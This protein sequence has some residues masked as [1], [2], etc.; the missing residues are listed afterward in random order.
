[1]IGKCARG[2]ACLLLC[3]GLAHAQSG[4]GDASLEFVVMTMA[5]VEGCIRADD[6]LRRTCTRI[7][8]LP[9]K[10]NANCALPVQPFEVRNARS[11]L[12]FKEAFRTQ[13]AENDALLADVIKRGNESF[14]REFAQLREGRI[15]MFDLEKLSRELNGR[16]ANVERRWLDPN[17]WPK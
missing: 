5:H 13:I 7:V 11:V 6:L 15:S 2:I 12:A 1:V 16:C 3:C 9:A 4:K 10:D 14:D 17:R 8:R